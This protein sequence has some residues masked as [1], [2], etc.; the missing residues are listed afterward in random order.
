MMT[1]LYRADMANCTGCRIDMANCSGYQ[2]D[3]ANWTAVD[4]NLPW[5][6]FWCVQFS[7][8]HFESA[9]NS[10]CVQFGLN[11]SR[12]LSLNWTVLAA[13]R[14]SGFEC[15]LNVRFRFLEILAIV[16][17]ILPRLNSSVPWRCE[18]TGRALAAPPVS[19]NFTAAIL[20]ISRA[21][22]DRGFRTI[23]QLF[24]DWVR[25][26]VGPRLTGESTD[27]ISFSFVLIRG[28]LKRG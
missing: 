19:G 20:Q 8:C 5:T 1:C 27:S 28:R 13:S 12:V 15:K 9:F 4:V 10:G 14:Q 17:Y 22:I 21:R 25:P 6:N 23:K 16:C 7:W 11:C 18:M 2:T 24:C 3:M 26:R